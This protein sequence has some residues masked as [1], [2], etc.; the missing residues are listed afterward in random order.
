[1]KKDFNNY[2]HYCDWIMSSWKYQTTDLDQEIIK[3]G[4]LIKIKHLGTTGYRLMFKSEF[5]KK[6]LE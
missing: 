1:M 2:K 4:F 6:M 5:D 3:N